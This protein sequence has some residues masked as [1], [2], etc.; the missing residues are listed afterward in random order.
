MLAAVS[1][2]FFL[3]LARS[4]ILKQAAHRVGMGGPTGFVRQFV[5]GDTLEEAIGAVRAVEARGMRHS[6]DYLGGSPTTLAGA[7]AAART[8]L[9]IIDAAVRAGVGRHL[10]IGLTQ[11]GLDLDPASSVDNLRRVLTHAERHQAFVT[12]D[13]DGS[14]YTSAALDIFETVWNQGFHRVGI[15][16]QAALRRSEADLARLLAL[17]ASVLIVKGACGEPARIAYQSR[18]DVRAAFLRLA[19][20]ALAGGASP[21]IGTHDDALVG[22][23][24]RMAAGR[25][26]TPDRFEFEMLYGIR[27]DLQASLAAAGYQ[28]RVCTPF[29]PEWFTWLMRRLADRPAGVRFVARRLFTGR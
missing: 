5:A 20:Q 29:G 4:R 26:V 6:L 27:Q 17:G 3:T 23:V 28:V 21:A 9:A 15:V 22:G 1:R 11:I 25:G 18:A 12:I 19:E 2:A 8:Y 24:R 16:V 7:E 13:T 10:S 14:S